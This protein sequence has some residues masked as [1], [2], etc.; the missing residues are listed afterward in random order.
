MVAAGSATRVLLAD[1]HRL[2]R[3]GVAS[4]LERADDVELVGESATGEEAVHLAE[5]LAADVVLMDI[6]MPGM[7]GIEATRTIVGRSPHVGVIVVTMFEDDESVFAALKAGARGYVLKDAD[8]GELLRAIRAVARG[9]ALLGAAVARRVLE[10][11]S[12]R[13]PAP[14]PRALQALHRSSTSS[15]PGAGGAASHSSGLKN[16]EISARLHISE[17][18]VGNHVS[19]VFRKLQ[20][21]D[22]VQAI[23]R[24]REAGWGR[25]V[26]ARR[27]LDSR[28]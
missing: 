23:I 11:F 7:D 12:G 13:P 4:L 6:K 28:G 26:G 14:G 1:D 19:N 21:A 9:E 3:E 16:R 20:V 27:A 18:T 24:A 15:P 22:R 17:K 25:R 2:F 5:E 8:R 10:Q